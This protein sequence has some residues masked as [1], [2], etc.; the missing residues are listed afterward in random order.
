ME[1]SF[2]GDLCLVLEG[3]D[4]SLG[5]PTCRTAPAL[6]QWAAPEQSCMD[7]GVCLCFL[8]HQQPRCQGRSFHH[9]DDAKRCREHRGLCRRSAGSHCRGEHP[10]G[11][12]NG[13]RAPFCR[14]EAVLQPNGAKSTSVSA[15]FHAPLSQIWSHSPIL[16]CQGDPSHVPAA[17]RGFSTLRSSPKSELGCPGEAQEPAGGQER[18][19]QSTMRILLSFPFCCSCLAA[20]ATELKK[21]NPL[22]RGRWS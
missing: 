9:R 5:S 8:P 3:L 12:K 13:V 6:N 11:K 18:L 10:K 2:C 19:T 17:S 21:Q 7:L 1:T 20:M 22:Q 14:L 15:L 4:T 16:T